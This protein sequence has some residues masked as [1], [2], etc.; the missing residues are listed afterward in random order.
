[1]RVLIT[2]A[3]GH[4]GRRLIARLVPAVQ[5][6]ATVRSAEA[7]RVLEQ[8]GADVRIVELDYHDAHALAEAAADCDCAVHLVGILKETVKNRYVDAHE[9][10]TDV[11]VAAATATRLRRIIYLSIL[12]SDPLSQNAALASKG[13]A[14]RALLNGVPQAVVLRVPMVLG[15]D[16]HAAR[17]LSRKARGGTVFLLRGA[18][19]EQPIYAGDVVEAIVAAMNA[20]G[21]ERV[22]IDLAGPES[23][24]R[25]ALVQRAAATIGRR[26]RCIS[27]PLAPLLGVAWIAQHAMANPPITAAMLGVLDHD[28]CIDPAAAATQLGIRLTS[29]DEMLRRCVRGDGHHAVHTRKGTSA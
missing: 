8:S 19:L 20:P 12:G 5:V 1:V 7:R 11:L 2:G 14:E 29:L 3:N 18:S 16:D 9:R 4:L 17:A 6:T 28:D 21:L 25:E 10:T 15:E 27:L 13:R 22:A 24:S 26:V 23:L